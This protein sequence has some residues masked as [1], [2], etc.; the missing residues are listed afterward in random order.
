[1][2]VMYDY[3]KRVA[4]ICFNLLNK[5]MGGNLP[6]FGSACVIVEEKNRYLV[7]KLPGNRVVF[8]GG[9]MKWKETPPQAAEREGREETGLE[10]Q[11]T[12]LVNFYTKT[13][14]SWTTM[15]NISFVFAGRIVNGTLRNNVEGQPCWID[16]HE[17]RPL[18]DPHAQ[19]LLTDYIRYRTAR[20]EA[21]GESSALPL[22]S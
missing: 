17:L 5:L 20:K 15:S 14:T 6:P 8:P 12:G 19:V 7:V 4:A 13:A 22:V 18:L 11:T 9:F 16:E 2:S 3:L 1:M 21:G 10:I